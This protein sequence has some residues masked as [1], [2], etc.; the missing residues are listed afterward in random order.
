MTTKNYNLYRIRLANGVMICTKINQVL[1]ENMIE[2]EA[3][4]ESYIIGGGEYLITVIA[5]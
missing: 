3:L 4:L 5:R 1:A 2:A